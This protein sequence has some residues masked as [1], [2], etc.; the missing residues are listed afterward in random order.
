MADGLNNREIGEAIGLS[1][2][3]V[4]IHRGTAIKKLGA[5]NGTHAAVLFDRSNRNG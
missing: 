3:T 2:R 4:E 5:K 1:P